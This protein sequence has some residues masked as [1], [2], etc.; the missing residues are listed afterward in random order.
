MGKESTWSAGDAGDMG[1]IP[2][3]G[4]SQPGGYGNPLRYSYLENPMGR[5]AWKATVHR[6][7]RSWTQPK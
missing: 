6:V 3:L 4:R 7:T 2:R 5:G 1:S